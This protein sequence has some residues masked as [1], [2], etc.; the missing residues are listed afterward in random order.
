MK[1]LRTHKK[2][3]IVLPDLTRFYIE[4]DPSPIKFSFDIHH[5]GMPFIMSLRIYSRVEFGGQMKNNFPSLVLIV[6]LYFHV[7]PLILKVIQ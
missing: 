1:K 3:K 4:Y 5:R 7:S 2:K 6:F